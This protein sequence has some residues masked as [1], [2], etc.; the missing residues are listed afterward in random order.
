MYIIYLHSPCIIF[1]NQNRRISVLQKVGSTY[2]VQA[3]TNS[4]QKIMIMNIYNAMMGISDRVF[5]E[6]IENHP[7]FR[8]VTRTDLSIIINQLPKS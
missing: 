1:S 3:C 2:Y 6:L 5:L 7:F 8:Q 4:V